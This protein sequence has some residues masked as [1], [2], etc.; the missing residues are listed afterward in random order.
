M[1]G[2]GIAPYD[3]KSQ[4]PLYHA[5]DLAIEA[6][7]LNAVDLD[8]KQLAN[9]LRKIPAYDLIAAAERLKYWDVDPLVPKLINPVVE[10]CTFDK[11]GQTSSFLCA[12]PRDLWKQGKYPKIPILTGNSEIEGGVRGLAIIENQTL[13][14][15][16][17]EILGEYLPLNF[18][19]FRDSKEATNKS[20]EQIFK[21][22]L[23]GKN[24]L[25][26][27]NYFGLVDIFSDRWFR[28]PLLRTVQQFVDLPE[29]K[30]HPIYI[31]MFNYSGPH[32]YSTWF[33][34]SQDYVGVIHCDELIYTLHSPALFPDFPPDS[35]ETKF[36]KTW[37][38][39][40]IDFAKDG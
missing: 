32:S 26:P 18:N 30:N 13:V 23:N 27:E 20:V 5:I 12:N 22:Y 16:L 9:E 35:F 11:N 7:I 19:F 14:Q 17:N 29:N 3:Y 25:D 34:K 38:K 6:G 10:N 21:T 2:S 28:Q 37:I 39:F 8:T 31:Y 1:S 33:S 40:L 36:R 15:S 24:Y 4:N